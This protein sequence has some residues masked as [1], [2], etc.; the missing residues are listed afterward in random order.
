MLE[1]AAGISRFRYRKEEAER[2]LARTDENLLRIND[3]IDELE[4]QVGPAE[5]SRRRW[6]SATS[7]CATS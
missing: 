2:R 4:L 6:R 3:K 5:A 1:E 7:P